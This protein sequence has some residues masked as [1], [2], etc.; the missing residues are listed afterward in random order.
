[1]PANY[2]TEY[3]IKHP[4]GFLDR[5][6]EQLNI[7][8]SFTQGGMEKTLIPDCVCEQILVLCSDSVISSS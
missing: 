1:M 3:R 2:G 6:L 8:V 7:P 4:D 5:F